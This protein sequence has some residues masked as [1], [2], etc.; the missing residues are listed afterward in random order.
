MKKCFLIGLMVLAVLTVWGQEKSK[1][2]SSST[3][4]EVKQAS[5]STVVNVYYFHG[6]QRCKTCMAVENVT[7]ETIAKAYGGN[8]NVKFIE[9]KTEDKANA[10][11]VEKYKVTWNALIIEK[12]KDYIDL[13]RQGFANAVNKP[14]VLSE[15]IQKEVNARL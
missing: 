6:K 7:K 14:E 11:L 1:K 13:T 9:V 12:G 15:L 3:K 10:P 2:A 5:A 8:K 4:S